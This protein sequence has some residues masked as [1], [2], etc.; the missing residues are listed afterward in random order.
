MASLDTYE[1]SLLPISMDFGTYS[2]F[3]G[4]NIGLPTPCDFLFMEND[5]QSEGISSEVLHNTVGIL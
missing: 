4:S 1:A 3:I 2:V 5:I